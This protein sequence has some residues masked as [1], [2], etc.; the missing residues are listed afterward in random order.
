M[1]L[2]CL[3]EAQQI[4][5]KTAHKT[6]DVIGMGIIGAIVFVGALGLGFLIFDGLRDGRQNNLIRPDEEMAITAVEVQA[7]GARQ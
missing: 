3:D 1:T 6:L 2:I 7:H 4:K 5:I